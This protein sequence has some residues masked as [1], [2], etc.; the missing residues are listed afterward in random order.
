VKG[1]MVMTCRELI[2]YILENRL[3]NEEVFANGKLIGFMTADEIAVMCNTGSG[4]IEAF[5]DLFNIPSI[6]INNTVYY[7]ANTV[8]RYKVLVMTL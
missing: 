1:E 3:E 8:Q 5:A 4:T 6:T 2:I 7:P